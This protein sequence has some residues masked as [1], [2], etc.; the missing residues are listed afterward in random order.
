M[1]I[2]THKKFFFWLSGILV[3]GA[4]A[5]VGIFGLNFGI[6]FMGGSLMEIRYTQERPSVDALEAEAANAGFENTVFQPTEENG[7]IV[8]AKSLGEEERLQMLNVLSID[9]QY[10]FAEERFT[11]IGPT[12]GNELKQKAW[13]ALAAVIGAI[14]LFI[15]FAFRH[16][17]EPVSSWKYGFIAILALLHDILIPT[18]VFA[19]LGSLFLTYQVD[20]L[21]VMALLAI[22][23]FSVNDTIVVFDRVRENLTVNQ[24]L[25]PKKEQKKTFNQVVGESLTQTY[26]RSLNTSLTTLF[27]LVLLFF[28]GGETTQHFALTLAIGVIAG[29][30]SSIFLASPLLTVFAGKEAQK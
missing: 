9:N 20:V 10:P 4:I 18:G 24:N 17:S 2:I 14:I 27:V 11:S 25:D 3:A 19:I 26:A 5:A 8:R 7:M 30:Y 12:I 6:D 13:I 21:F 15:A 22:L 28:I 29:T 16:V 23:G 1:F